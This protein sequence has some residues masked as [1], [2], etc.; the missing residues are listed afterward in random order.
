MKNIITIIVI[1]AIFMAGL[2]SIES[3]RRAY[4]LRDCI[5]KTKTNSDGL[6]I[7]KEDADLCIKAYDKRTS[8]NYELQKASKRPV[9]DKKPILL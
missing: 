9:I 4:A 1:L 8:R 7:D 3:D 5:S 6:T 2:I